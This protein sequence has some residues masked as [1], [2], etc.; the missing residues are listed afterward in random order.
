M[1]FHLVKRQP[2]DHNELQ[3]N[4]N[5][6]ISISFNFRKCSKPHGPKIYL[7][8]HLPCNTH[9]SANSLA[10]SDNE[11]KIDGETRLVYVCKSSLCL[12]LWMGSYNKV[13]NTGKVQRSID[14]TTY[15]SLMI[16]KAYM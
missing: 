1:H 2:N 4:Y 3:T 13:D 12:F 7:T 5:F 9:Q 15:L 11:D 6:D 10:S 8:A 14:S 16:L